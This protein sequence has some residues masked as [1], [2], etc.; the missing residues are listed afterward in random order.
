[1]IEALKILLL[2][3]IQGIGEFLPISSS[4]HLLVLG[5][6]LFGDG[7][8]LDDGELMTL[9]ILLHGGTLLSILIIFYRQIWEM[10][11]SNWRLI[12]L[13]IV[14]SIPA[15][16]LGLFVKKNCEFLEQ[17]LPI[18]GI[19]FFITAF[20][21]FRIVAP[22]KKIQDAVNADNSLKTLR[23]MSWWDAF[24]IGIFQGVAI[25]PGFSRSGF[26]I[27]AGLLRKLRQEDAASFSFLLAIPAIAGATLLEIKDLLEGLSAGGGPPSY[28][29]SQLGLYLFGAFV[30]FIVGLVS[31]IY[32]LKWLKAGKL[33][34]FG[35]WLLVI[36]T[37][38]LIW[39]LYLTSCGLL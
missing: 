9:G 18:A 32:L 16:C 31:L 4:G 21:L 38:V 27:S 33:H 29:S 25:L 39:S 8:S 1:M 17:S 7:S 37:V 5:K 10:L 35:Y 36:G 28:T 34:Y 14:G 3:I 26:T 2:A 6:V 13:L 30:S 12:G 19:G 23:T 15:G 24:F 22:S 11:T 20:L